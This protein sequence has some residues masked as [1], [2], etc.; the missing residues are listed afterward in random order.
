MKHDPTMQELLDRIRKAHADDVAQAVDKA[1]SFTAVEERLLRPRQNMDRRA[2]M[3]A[4]WG[5]WT[6]LL[7]AMLLYAAFG[8]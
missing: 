3:M 6:L 4:V 8:L 7:L 5:A 1:R 2:V